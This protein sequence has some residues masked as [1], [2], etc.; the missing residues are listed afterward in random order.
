MLIG[1]R[2]LYTLYFVIVLPLEIVLQNAASAVL[3]PNIFTTKEVPPR[4]SVAVNAIDGENNIGFSG[5]GNGILNCASTA[6]NRVWRKLQYLRI[7]LQRVD[8]IAAVRLHLR[9][10]LNRQKWQN[11]LSVRVS[12]TTDLNS[13]H[14][15]GSNLYNADRDGQSPVFVCLKSATFIWAVVSRRNIPVQVCEVQAFNGRFV[16]AF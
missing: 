2:Q 8:F 6:D 5:T 9:D 4:K 1:P 16:S 12:N 13:A 10:G 3:Y 11:G 7:N 15:C 14:Q